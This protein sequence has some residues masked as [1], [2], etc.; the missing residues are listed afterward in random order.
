MRCGEIGESNRYKNRCSR[1]W[2][3]SRPYQAGAACSGEM[4][5]VGRRPPEVPRDSCRARW[6]HRT[7]EEVRMCAPATRRMRA[8]RRQAVER[9]R[10]Q[11]RR[12]SRCVAVAAPAV[13]DV[14]LAQKRHATTQRRPGTTSQLE[15]ETSLQRAEK[16]TSQQQRRGEA[17][18][19]CEEGVQ[20]VRDGTDK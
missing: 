12:P 3:T 7:P 16:G 11:R 10:M 17:L 5:S 13:H 14:I 19:R 4:R 9:R 1:S 8:A 15:V 20:C 6:S 18:V 2:R